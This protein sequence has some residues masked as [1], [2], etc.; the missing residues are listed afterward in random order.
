MPQRDAVGGLIPTLNH[1]NKIVDADVVFDLVV[2]TP[3][4]AKLRSDARLRSASEILDE[5]DLIYRIDWACVDARVNGSPTPEGV[6]CD[7]VQERHHAL[8]WL[9]GYQ[10][11]AWDDV[12]TDT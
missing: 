10:R 12:S 4:P 5:A 1:P 11:Q 3:G 9:I 2:N 6:D 8:N 7:V